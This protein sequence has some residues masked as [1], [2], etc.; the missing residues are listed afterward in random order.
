M[1]EQRGQNVKEF[2]FPPLRR[3]CVAAVP[4]NRGRL[5]IAVRALRRHFALRRPG[6]AGAK[7]SALVWAGRAGGM[8]GV[9][10]VCHKKRYL[11]CKKVSSCLR[12]IRVSRAGARARVE[13]G[14]NITRTIR[15]GVCRGATETQLK[16]H[17][18]KH[19]TKEGKCFGQDL[20]E[21]PRT[22]RGTGLKLGC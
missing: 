4:S 12:A 9:R 1:I 10:L 20:S 13:R 5:R 14:E 3:V 8:V 6:P 22:M 21:F 18:P 17:K 2:R 15:E 19:E 11:V 7:C 16:Y